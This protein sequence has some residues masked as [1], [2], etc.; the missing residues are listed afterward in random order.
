MS[1]TNQS[2]MSR[3]ELIETRTQIKRKIKAL[4]KYSNQ[5]STKAEIE[6]LENTLEAIR[7]E[8][9]TR[10]FSIAQQDGICH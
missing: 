10:Q 1:T 7:I 5:L 2:V 3:A 8:L 9:C 6:E 4:K